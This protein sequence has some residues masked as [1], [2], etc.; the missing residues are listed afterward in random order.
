MF[1][2]F[3]ITW[4]IRG[5]MLDFLSCCLLR[6]PWPC[7]GAAITLFAWKMAGW[8]VVALAACCLERYSRGHFGSWDKSN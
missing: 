3:T 1:F 6:T 8:K 2:D 5:A 4:A 7:D